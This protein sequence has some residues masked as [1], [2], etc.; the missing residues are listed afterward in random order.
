MDAVSPDRYAV[1]FE[2][3]SIGPVTTKNRFYQV[4][5]CTGMGYALPKTLA[6]MRAVK[7]EGGWGVV[8]TE[9]CSIHP[10]SDD[11]PY[12]Y[13]TLWDDDDVANLALMTDAVHVHGAL[14]GVQLWHGGY[15]SMNL[16]TREAPLAPVGRP[17]FYENPR[18]A[19]GMDKADIRAFRGWHLAAAKRAKRAGFDIVYVYAGHEYLPFQ[20]LSS[21]LNR[22][23]DEYGGPV[24]NRTR[25]LRELVEDTKDAIGDTCAVA[26]RLAVDELLGESGICYTG[27]GREIVECLAE[28][29]DLWDINLSDVGNDSCSAR[30]SEEGFQ[31]QYVSFVKSVTSKPVVGVGRFTSPDTMVRQVRGGVLDLIGAARPSIADPFIPN[32]IAEGRSEDIRECIGCNICRASNNEGVP[33]RCTQNPTM[34]EEWRS[35][36]HPERVPDKCS[37]A[38]VLVVGA[39]PAGL[40]CTRVLGQRGYEVTLAEA[41]TELGGRVILE[42]QLPGLASW[43]RVRDYRA[44]Q[45]APLPNVSVYLDSR[46]SAANVLEFGFDY[47]VLALGASWR[48]DG[49]GCHNPQPVPIAGD[50]DVFTPDDIMSGAKPNGPVVV[51]DDEHYYMGGCIA[52]QLKA[53]GCEV[54]LL[55]TGL[56]VSSWTHRTNEQPRV[57]RKLMELGVNI[58]TA[59]LLTGVERDHLELACIY[60]GRRSELAYG[61]LVLVTGRESNDALYYE[62]AN[63]AQKLVSSSVKSLARIGDCHVPGALVHAVYDGHRCARTLEEEPGAAERRRERVRVSALAPRL[64][65]V[66]QR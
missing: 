32:K 18:Q 55:T 6:A 53:L 33:I 44:Q 11:A 20:F 51:Y 63:D 9:Y 27:E 48:R 43:L 14:A 49:I 65:A 24:E 15:H 46:L 66:Q 38:T 50:S 19:R 23:D 8:C 54:T 7:A 41:G 5:H 60:T 22:R 62:I 34:G 40:E 3:V 59:K 47:V 39:G 36:W 26:V 12:A 52:E 64:D 25:L 21:R 30:F 42:S 57:Q 29:P 35:G 17:C 61:S 10:S 58:I 2:P 4:P 1:L 31:E 56:E 45:I 16:L 37:E 13:A 28:L